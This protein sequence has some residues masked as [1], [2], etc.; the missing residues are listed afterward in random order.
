MSAQHGRGPSGAGR[1]TASGSASSISQADYH[2]LRAKAMTEG[3][4]QI[5]VVEAAKRRG[6]LVYHTHDSRRSQAGYPD[7]HLV[8]PTAGRSL[9]RELKRE[10]GIVSKDQK[11]WLAALKLAGLDAGVWRPIHWFDGTIDHELDVS[12]P[13]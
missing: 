3:Q 1:N 2:V 4:L 6:W 11:I 13:W 7:L 8:H 5:A 10:T 12:R 9:L